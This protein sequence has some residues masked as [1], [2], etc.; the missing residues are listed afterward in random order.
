[1]DKEI[2]EIIVVEG[3]SDT[4]HLRSFFKGIDTIE[5]KGSAIDEEVIEQIKLAQKNR[6][7]IVLT[8]PDFN[9]NKIR[10]KIIEQ[11]PDAKQAFL[12]RTKAVP[13]HSGHSLGVEHAT[14]EDLIDA[15]NHVATPKKNSVQIERSQ[16]IDLKLIG[17]PESKK[18]REEVGDKLHIGYGNSK[19]FLSKVNRFNITIEELKEAI[20]Q[21][22]K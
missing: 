22:S 21:E 15:L 6:G 18:L 2:N 20:S 8:D 16:L 3:K 4:I 5:T 1:M 17:Y 19:Q 12:P 9:G 10:Q 7:V 11:I 14:K 13:K